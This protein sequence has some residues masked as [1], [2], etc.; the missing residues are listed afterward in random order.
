MTYLSGVA[1]FTAGGYSLA[2]LLGISRNHLPYDISLGWFLGAGYYSLCWFILAY[3]LGL[4]V[5]PLFSFV[6]ILLPSLILLLRLWLS[7]QSVIKSVVKKRAIE[8]L[9]GNKFL[10][11]NT[12]LVI[13]SIL[14]FTLVALHGTSTPSNGDDA[15]RLRALTPILVHDSGVTETT[16][17]MIFRSGIWPT[18][19]TLLFW[20]IGGEADHF[21]VNYTIVTSLFFFLS[22]LYLGPAI[23]GNSQQG[24]YNLFLVT[25]IPLFAYHATATYADIRL[26]IP[27]ALGFMF[28]TFYIRGK[29][30]ADLKTLILFFTI[31]C[32]VKAKGEIAGITG[33]SVTAMFIAYNAVRKKSF[34]N[35]RVAC[36]LFPAFIYFTVKNYYGHN[37]HGLAELAKSA[38]GQMLNVALVSKT[39]TPADEYK[40]QGFWESLF[41]SGNF[42]IIFYVLIANIFM[43]IKRILTT[44]LIWEL[45]F[46]S[47]VFMEIYYYMVMRFNQIEMHPAIVH[48]TVIMLSVIAALFLASLWSRPESAK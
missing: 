9:P 31:A 33:L 6:I 22:L 29:E 28:F 27:F 25:S 4:P 26:A 30:A 38:T 10:S 8:Y 12:I 18:F 36:F 16:S 41:V 39:I 32:F 48:R 1:L 20:H 47:L 5:R 2:R 11:L 19:T 15:M 46:T 34:P 37:L 42:G 21:Y 44:P 3:T 14:I 23:R 35:I 17:P 13:Y 43:D 45:F 40:L 24:I 7:P